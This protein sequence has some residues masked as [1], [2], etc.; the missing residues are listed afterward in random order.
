MALGPSIVTVVHKSTVAVY[1]MNCVGS[2]IILYSQLKLSV[3]YLDLFILFL[4][5]SILQELNMLVTAL[6]WNNFFKTK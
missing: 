3:I 5:Y 2:L 4:L 1:F 6:S